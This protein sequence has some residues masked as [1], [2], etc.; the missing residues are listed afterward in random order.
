MI[1]RVLLDD[2]GFGDDREPEYGGGG[3]D[4]MQAERNSA[5]H[6]VPSLRSYA[7]SQPSDRRLILAY[8]L[9][10]HSRGSGF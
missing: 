9:S 1:F 3:G 7:G 5:R 4:H 6:E 8:P 10:Q 2:S